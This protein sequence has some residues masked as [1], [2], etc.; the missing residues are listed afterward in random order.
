[1]HECSILS[2]NYN[3]FFSISFF[4]ISNGTFHCVLHG[5]VVS[6]AA[7]PNFLRNKWRSRSFSRV[8]IGLFLS[9]LTFANPD[10]YCSRAI[11]LTSA[12]SSELLNLT[13]CL[14]GLPSLL[15]FACR[16]CL[17]FHSGFNNFVRSSLQTSSRH[18]IGEA[19]PFFVSHILFLERIQD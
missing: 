1:M 7:Y 13:E 6:K 2:F 12:S 14:T 15:V 16:L 8:S 5:C 11:S 10:R 4:L 18:L 9:V 3:F 17:I 19:L